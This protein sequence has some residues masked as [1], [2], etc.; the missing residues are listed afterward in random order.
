MKVEIS[1]LPPH[2]PTLP[3]GRL[4]CKKNIQPLSFRKY[5]RGGEGDILRK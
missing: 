1:P 5:A 4:Y 3:P 2:M